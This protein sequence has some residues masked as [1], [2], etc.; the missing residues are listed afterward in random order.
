MEIIK[1]GYTIKNPH[2]ED[3]AELEKDKN[4]LLFKIYKC[5]FLAIAPFLIRI[6]Q[7]LE[8]YIRGNNIMIVAKRLNK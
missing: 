6:D 1:I 3:Q 2:F 5:I 4:T 7:K 8:K